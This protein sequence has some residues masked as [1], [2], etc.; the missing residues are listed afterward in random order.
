MAK[1][2]FFDESEI[3][4]KPKPRK[5]PQA[6][7]CESCGL[8]RHCIHPRMEPHGDNALNIA[9]IAE[10]PGEEEDNIGIP[11]VGPAGK[12]LRRQFDRF[13]VD[14]DR[15]C[16]KQNVIQCRPPG[17]RTPTSSELLSC[18]PRLDSQL[19]K[20]K[21][22]LIFAFGTP[23]IASILRDAPFSPTATNMHGRVVPSALWNCWVACGFH[24]SYYLHEK[25]RHDVLMGHCIRNG[26]AKL[27]DGPYEDI[28][29]DP[30]GFDVVEDVDEIRKLLRKLGRS[31]SPVAIDYETKGLNPWRQGFRILTMGLAIDQDHG[32]CIPLEHRQSKI[33][34]NRLGE[35]NRAIVD[36]LKSDAPKVIQNWQFE[37]L[38]SIVYLGTPIN[39]VVCDTMI[40]EHILDN[41]EG[42]CGQAFQ[43]YV[44]Y[45]EAR[46]KSSINVAQLD[47]E[48][49]ETVARYNVLDCRY[50]IRWYYDQEKEITP[51]LRDA[52]SLFHEAIPVFVRMKIRGIKLDEER[53]RGIA[54][55]T[56]GRLKALAE[57]ERAPCLKAYKQKYGKKWDSGSGQAKQRLFFDILGLKPLKLTS[58]GTDPDNPLHCST[59]AESMEYLKTQVHEASLERCLINMC[60]E[61]SHLVKLNG[62]IQNFR[63][64][65]DDGYLHPSFLL[66]RVSSYRSSSAD[67]NFQNVPVRAP[68][69]AKLR[70]SLVPR[71][72]WLME[73]DFSGAEVRMIATYSK[74][75]N[76]VSNIKN[77]VDYHRHYAALLY[78]K[79]EEDITKKERYSGKNC[80]VF[81]EF[82]G[83]YYVQIAA[84]VPEW[85]ESRVEKVERLFW[86]D[87]SGVRRWQEES[88]EFYKR[89]GYF[90]YLDGF[91]IRFS[92]A[93][94]LKRKNVIN[95]PIQGT[96]FHRLLKVL[97]AT[98]KEMLKRRMSSLL[99]G[100]IHDS[101]VFDV[102]EEEIPELVEITS[103]II[104]R[105]Q[106]EWDNVV[107]WGAEFKIG[108][109]L[110][111]MEEI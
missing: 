31:D 94:G 93:G 35:V 42:V 53:L 6:H 91:R 104:K 1:S 37:E 70:T 39:N 82:Y 26:L 48:F 75:E 50:A 61:G 51:R 74:D 59:D 9:I 102:I 38:V 97:L 60:L 36:F 30:N 86:N 21:P 89:H 32:Y 52:Y 83:D 110:L 95:L 17:N 84:S 10:A 13:G 27:R 66:H 2:F 24:P 11:L 18:R 45:G 71:F 68:S 80:F 4:S 79:K 64:M 96:A 88:D 44:R 33:P 63:D 81:P 7:T 72:D 19:R 69:L 57:A 111:E 56:R 47:R 65:A 40:R 85:E 101:I 55:D 73:I 90:D 16:V 49:L 29:L 105:P 12:F 28:R 20:I 46:H 99:I 107:P 109:N 78:D 100:Q 92:K 3:C 34:G 25:G 43:E 67:P 98:E 108:K 23:A 8:Y 106:W 103:E 15:D 62:Y 77:N 22:D 5:K 58:K 41:R 87:H 54:D 76:L 14:I